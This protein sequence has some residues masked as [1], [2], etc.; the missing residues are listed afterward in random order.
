MSNS[1]KHKPTEFYLY[2]YQISVDKSPIQLQLG[3]TITPEKLY[4]ERNL[5]LLRA[6]E[7]IVNSPAQESHYTY[8]IEAQPN[9]TQLLL[10]VQAERTKTI[11]QNATDFH[12]QHQPYGWV[13]IDMDPKIQT[14]GI[15][16]RGDLKAKHVLSDLDKKLQSILS[17]QHLNIYIEAIR[18]HRAFW[19]IVDDNRDKIKE[20]GIIINPPNMPELTSTFDKELSQFTESAGAKQTALILKA[21]KDAT[22]NIEE[23][24]P[25]LNALANCADQGGAKYYFKTT[26]SKTKITPEGKQDILRGVPVEDTDRLNIQTDGDVH[27]KSI[28][29]RIREWCRLPRGQE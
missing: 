4:K 6:L 21:K 13:A 7:T 3:E 27:H 20:V 8:K 26:E 29:T 16:S 9:D 12:I 24:N 23:S 17:A 19:E 18:K 10:F 11:I 15:S 22:L 1:N 2:R 25:R 5:Y 14:I 28:L